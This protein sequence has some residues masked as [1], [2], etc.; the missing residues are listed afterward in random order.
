MSFHGTGATLSLPTLTESSVR[1]EAVYPCRPRNRLQLAVHRAI[2]RVGRTCTLKYRYLKLEDGETVA[3]ERVPIVTKVVLSGY[4]PEPVLAEI[5]QRE[6][7]IRVSFVSVD[8]G[9]WLDIRKG[10]RFVFPM[11]TV[12]ANEVDFNYI[13]DSLVQYVVTAV[14]AIE[15]S[16]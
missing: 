13:G 6:S 9:G 11:F 1:P 5:K 10:T 7:T 16:V 12:T 14:G 8:D 15:R 4:K 2:Q 3:Y